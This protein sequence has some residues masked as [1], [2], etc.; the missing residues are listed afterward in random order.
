M[1]YTIKFVNFTLG[2]PFQKSRPLTGV[3]VLPALC[4]SYAHGFRYRKCYLTTRFIMIYA[5]IISLLVQ[6]IFGIACLILLLM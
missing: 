1:T 3:R 5:N 6:L 2:A 4:G